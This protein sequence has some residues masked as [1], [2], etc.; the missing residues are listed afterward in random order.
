[1]KASRLTNVLSKERIQFEITF[2][3]DVDT[4]VVS[5]EHDDTGNFENQLVLITIMKFF[6]FIHQIFYDVERNNIQI[7]FHFPTD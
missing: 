2:G 4:V 1:M 3:K 5:F 7:N 6:R